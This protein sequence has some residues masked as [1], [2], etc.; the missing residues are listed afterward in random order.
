MQ[1]RETSLLSRW[2]KKTSVGW[3]A[4]F[5]PG[6]GM[7]ALALVQSRAGQRPLLKYC[8]SHATDDISPGQILSTYL[9]GRTLSHSAVSAVI[10]S[11][12]YQLVQ[13]EAPDV[14]ATELRAA[15]RWKLRDLINFPVEDAVVDVFDTPPSPRQGRE[16]MLYAVAARSQAVTDMVNLVKPRARGF[17]VIDIPELCL[18]NLSALLPQNERGVALL[19]L[20]H[21][22][23]QLLLTRQG[24]LYL[25]RR[26]ELQRRG[27]GEGQFDTATLALE[28]Q[29]SMDYYESHFDLPAITSLVIASSD[30]SSQ[31]LA[32]QLKSETSLNIGF[33]EPQHYFE[34]ADGTAIDTSWHGLIA[35]GAAL[36]SSSMELTQ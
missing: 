23:A 5:F 11:D 9:N 3:R 18:R 21:G 28:I 13:V 2:N 34:I 6:E 15:V 24:T 30:A 10:A 20:D 22:V 27:Y 32:T 7:A 25:S 17:D 14:P 33:F 19:T 8:G 35:L 31:T 36:R 26:I 12:A 29:R 1:L 4:G 16:K